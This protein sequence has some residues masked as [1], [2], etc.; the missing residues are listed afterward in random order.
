VPIAIIANEQ[1]VE[2][3]SGSRRRTRRRAKLAEVYADHV[4]I[5]HQGV[6]ERLPLRGRS[7]TRRACR[8]KSREPAMRRQ[9][10]HPDHH[11]S[12]AGPSTPVRAF[13][14]TGGS[15]SRI[16]PQEFARQIKPVFG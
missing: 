16:D 12:A 10:C 9:P 6:A 14:T 8:A 4:V 13:G 7:S 2:S 15:P 1:G 5:D 3:S 11:Q